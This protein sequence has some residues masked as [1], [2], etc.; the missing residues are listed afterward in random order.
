MF[1]RPQHFTEKPTF[2]AGLKGCENVSQG[3]PLQMGTHSLLH[4][5]FHPHL[6]PSVHFPACFSPLL[7]GWLLEP[8]ALKP[9]GRLAA[10]QSVFC[11][12]TASGS[13]WGPSGVRLHFTSAPLA[14]SFFLG[15]WPLGI[16]L[17]SPAVILLH[18]LFLRAGV[19]WKTLR[20]CTLALMEVQFG[21]RLLQLPVNVGDATSLHQ[22]REIR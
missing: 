18:A 19:T 12:C 8:V 3:C 4:R 5:N 15:R 20:R 11:S 22:S 10:Q 14:C 7:P 9:L 16:T 6:M 17:I 21:V 1:L 13:S 2:T